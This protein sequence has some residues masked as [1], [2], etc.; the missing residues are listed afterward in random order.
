MREL[1]ALRLAHL[2]VRSELAL[3]NLE[4]KRRR[5]ARSASLGGGRLQFVARMERSEIRGKVLRS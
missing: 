5:L 1:Y 3:L 2:R 4:L